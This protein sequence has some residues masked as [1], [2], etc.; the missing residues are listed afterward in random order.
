MLN[1]SP[2]QVWVLPLCSKPIK[3]KS[4]LELL[5]WS[6]EGNCTVLLELNNHQ[7]WHTACEYLTTPLILFRSTFHSSLQSAHTLDSACLNFC[8]IKCSSNV[9]KMPPVFLTCYFTASCT[10]NDRV[11]S[12]STVPPGGQPK[13]NLTYPV[14]LRSLIYRLASK[15]GS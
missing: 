11:E 3:C 14:I 8:L 13:M 1:I 9:L 4:S 10:A 5:I 15:I 2:K 12:M 6:R 7:V